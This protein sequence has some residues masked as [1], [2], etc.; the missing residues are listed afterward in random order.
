MSV[1]DSQEG[2]GLLTIVESMSDGF[3]AV[4]K[5]WRLVYVNGRAEK[6]THQAKAELLGKPI[7]EV[8]PDTIGS[9]FY[10]HY[11]RKEADNL[12]LRFE[13]CCPSIDVW[14]EVRSVPSPFG[15]AFYFHDITEQ[16]RSTFLAA[17]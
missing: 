12:K 15:L 6:I 7:W 1:I 2:Q 14:L 5:Q 4:D 9:V 17:S 10:Q 13:L 8:F 3:C 11:H 16:R